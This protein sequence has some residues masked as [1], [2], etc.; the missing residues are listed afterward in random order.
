MLDPQQAAAYAR[1]DFAIP[2]QQ[3]ADRFVETFPNL[4]LTGTLLDLGCGPADLLI[5]IARH[6]PQAN[7]HGIDGSAVMLAEAATAIADAGLSHQITLFEQQLPAISLPHSDYPAIISNSLLHHLHDPGVLWQTIEQAAAP[8]AAIY[9]T[10]LRRPASTN[11]ARALVET[12]SGYE[13]A[14]L[15][16]DFYHSLLAAF[17]VAKVEQQLAEAGLDYLQVTETSDRHLQI[18]GTFRE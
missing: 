15:K 6:R 13:P 16:H 10:D 5:R 4:I 1:A 14:L 3:I 8:G 11:I 18:S 2:H 12:Y 7:F 9:V 17:T